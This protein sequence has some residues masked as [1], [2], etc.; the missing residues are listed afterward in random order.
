M[1]CLSHDDQA[2]EGYINDVLL[3][4]NN[5]LKIGFL[6]D[7]CNVSTYNTVPGVAIELSLAVIVFNMLKPS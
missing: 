5:S 4:C 2:E 7:V 1:L 3:R 6:T